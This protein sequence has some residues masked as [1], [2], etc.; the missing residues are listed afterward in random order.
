MD[1]FPGP[2]GAAPGGCGATRLDVRHVVVAG[3]DDH[4]SAANGVH[5]VARQLVR[6]QRAAGHDARLV[7]LCCAPDGA[8]E[9]DGA[10]R[11]PAR[12][13][14]V[15]GR[16]VRLGRGEVEAVLAGAGPGTVFHVHGGR[17]PMLVGLARRMHARGLPYAVTIHG[18]FSHVYDGDGACLR[19]STALYLRLVE[20]GMLERARFVQALSGDEARILARVAPGARIEVVGNGAYSSR[21]EASQ[22]RLEASQG[23]LEA[24]Q[25]VPPART[26]SPGFPHF[27]FC[28]RYAIHHK[29][30]DLLLHGFALYRRAGGAGHLT[31]VGSGPARGELLELAE[32]L[33]V[34]GSVVVDGPRYGAG[35]DAVL[36]GA[37]FFVMA[38]R[39]EG[40]PLAALEAGLLGLPLLV[41]RGTGLAEAVVAAGAGQRIEALDAGAVRDALQRAGA[42]GMAQWAAQAAAARRLVEAVGDWSR[43]AGRLCALYAAGESGA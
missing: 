4:P 24:S 3:R 10:T 25:G 2:S 11:L 39:Y 6:E 31:L 30:L 26:P 21:L 19:R 29:G 28:G 1:G 22:G 8:A 36:Q 14:A 41:T 16:V 7:I 20:R 43:I 37:D 32:R 12:G 42:T 27:V 15:R 9:A 23:R 13:V 38:S 33:G 5:N 40:V 35:R 34:A 17:E 18:R